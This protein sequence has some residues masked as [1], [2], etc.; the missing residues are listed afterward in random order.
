[1][2]WREVKEALADEVNSNPN[3]TPKPGPPDHPYFFQVDEEE[4]P[5]LGQWLGVSD[6]ESLVDFTMWCTLADMCVQTGVMDPDL[7][8]SLPKRSKDYAAKPSTTHESNGGDTTDYRTR[9]RAE[10]IVLTFLM[11]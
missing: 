8:P 3:P 4:L 2:P 10:V 9:T 6:D 11:A 7:L 5:Y 1:M